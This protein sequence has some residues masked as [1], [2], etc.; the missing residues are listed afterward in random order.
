MGEKRCSFS[1]TRNF[2]V[3]R[4]IGFFV[5]FIGWLM[6]SLFSMARSFATPFQEPI[7]SQ[8][9]TEYDKALEALANEEYAEAEAI[10]R[11]FI[12]DHPAFQEPSG[13]SAWHRLGEALLGLQEPYSAV[14]I[15]EQGK[16]VLDSV[17]FTDLYPPTSDL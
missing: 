16:A 17:G 15:L 10:L 2:H 6:G 13:R 9:P 5:L 7:Y 1:G 8:I 3:L 4:H 14:Q 12:D 11:R